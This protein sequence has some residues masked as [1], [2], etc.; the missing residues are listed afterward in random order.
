MD[1]QVEKPTRQQAKQSKMAAGKI[2]VVYYGKREIGALNPARV[3]PWSNMQMPAKA[4]RDL[5]SA[6]CAAQEAVNAGA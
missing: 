2:F 4:K 1:V 3:K 6:V 5:R